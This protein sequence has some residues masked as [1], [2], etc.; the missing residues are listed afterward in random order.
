LLLPCRAELSLGGFGGL[1]DLDEMSPGGPDHE[2]W[3]HMRE[4]L[5]E[6]AFVVT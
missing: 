5:M 3:E 1:D 2:M 4:G 6:Q